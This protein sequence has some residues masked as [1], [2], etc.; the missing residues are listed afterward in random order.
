VGGCLST[1]AWAAHYEG[2]DLQGASLV[3]ADGDTVS[4]VFTEVDAFVVPAGATVEVS[5]GW[6]EVYATTIEV[7]GVLSAAGAGALGGAPGVAYDTRYTGMCSFPSPGVQGEG[8]GGGSGA[9]AGQGNGGGGGG[10]G[11]SG[12]DGG[13]LGGFAFIAYAAPGGLPYGLDLFTDL[14][15]DERLGSGGGGGSARCLSW[16]ASGYSGGPGGAGGGALTLIATASLRITGTL[17]AGGARGGDAFAFP[18]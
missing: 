15:P 8:L 1:A 2:T 7:D 10:F 4:G 3:L 13:L 5:G 16:A 17:D 18:G 14:G 12:G 6:L 9:V 11:G